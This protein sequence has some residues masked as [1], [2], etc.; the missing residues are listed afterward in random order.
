MR[1]SHGGGSALNAIIDSYLTNYHRDH[2]EHGCASAALAADAGRHGI[3][4]QEEYRRG[5][6][7]F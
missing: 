3:Q 4:A 2:P 7:K 5:C 1:P 6:M